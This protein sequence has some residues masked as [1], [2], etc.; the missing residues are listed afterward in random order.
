MMWKTDIRPG[1]LQ[2]ACLMGAIL[3]LAPLQ[4]SAHTVPATPD[5]TAENVATENE[6]RLEV[7]TLET[8]AS[9]VDLRNGL[10]K[11]IKDVNRQIVAA[12]S[13]A[14]KQ[15]LKEQL[16]VLEADLR[17]IRRNF[18]NIAAGIDISVLR[19]E[20]AT[21]FSLQKELV[22]LLK[23]ALE[24][25]KDMTS[26]VRKKA[27]LREQIA[28][29]QKRLPVLENALANVDR[30]LAQSDSK[31]VTQG[32]ELTAAAWRKQM[33]LLQSELKSAEVRLEQ[34]IADEVSITEASGSYL[35]AF[36]QKRG[37]YLTV[38]LSVV[39]GIFFLSR[40]SLSA[41]RRLIPGFRK[42][43]RSFRVRLAELLH[44]VIT[45][46]LIILGPMVVFYVVED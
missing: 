1:Q 36:F 4:T 15:T 9:F 3:M 26:H 45:M 19:A 20:Q 16:N 40:L 23:P 32:L 7:N 37:L 10:L 42:P 8:L 14:E 38:A 30:L 46:V 22:A 2:F 33:A 18:E 27:D 6:Q 13:D 24:E 28:D 39:I 31:P 25:M 29:Y 41:I 17:A 12:E 34:L 11:D 44:R 5:D 21:E 43:H 35:K